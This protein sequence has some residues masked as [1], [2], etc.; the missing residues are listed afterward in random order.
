[1]SKEEL[2][3][4]IREIYRLWNTNNSDED[5]EFILTQVINII[6]K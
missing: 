3:K 1:M 5:I 4:V 6:G 2:I